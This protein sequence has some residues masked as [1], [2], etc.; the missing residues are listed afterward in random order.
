MTFDI[1]DTAV[2]V[3]PSRIT[4]DYKARIKKVVKLSFAKI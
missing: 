1:D 4:Q 3:P 2:E